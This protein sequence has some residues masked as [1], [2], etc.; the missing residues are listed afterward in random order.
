MVKIRSGISIL[1]FLLVAHS[2]WAADSDSLNRPLTLPDCIRIALE[3]NPAGRAAAA[4]VQGARE[5]V[6]EAGAPYYP[7][8]GLADRLPA[9][10]DPCLSARLGP[11]SRRVANRGRPDR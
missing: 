3:A 6:G 2:A 10:S 4:G 8:L 5:A 7:E 9:V 11:H 1:I